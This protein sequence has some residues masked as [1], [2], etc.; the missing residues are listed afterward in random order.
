MMCE[1]QATISI[2]KNLVHHDRTKHVEIDHH[3]ISEKV[4]KEV[5]HLN[6]VPP[7]QQIA[8]ILTKPLPR[9]NFDDLNSK[10][11]LYNIYNSP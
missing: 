1:N 11:G 3:F 5:V 9:P 4:N 7:K 2:A 6:Y 10:L 8:N